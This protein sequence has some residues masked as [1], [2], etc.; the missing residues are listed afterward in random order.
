M[1]NWADLPPDLLNMI[2]SKVFAKDR[3]SLVCRSWYLAATPYRYS[4]PCMMYYYRRNHSWKFHLHD[5]FFFTSF[6]QLNNSQIHCSKYG[7]LLMARNDNTLFFFDPSNNRALDLPC[8]NSFE[9]DKVFF[10][11]PPT[12]PDCIVVTISET[13]RGIEIYLLKRGEYEWE[14]FKFKS[15]NPY[16]VSLALPVLHRGQIILLDM[17]GNL[18]IFNIINRRFVVN[19]EC[20]GYEYGRIYNLIVNEHS[21]FTLKG[22]DALFSVFVFHEER[23]VKVFGLSKVS[24][25]IK[26]KLVEDIGDNVLYVSHTSCF[27][28]TAET[29]ATANRIYFPLF[30]GDSPVFYSLSDKKYHSLNGDYSSNDAYG[31]KRLEFAAWVTPS[32][33]T[34]TSELNTT[35]FRWTSSPR[36]DQHGN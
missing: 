25:K 22:K 16:F 3:F 12:S 31:L 28:C 32:L 1:G 21:L 5:S 19:Y 23:D 27:V 29:K 20:L 10:F 14:H 13:S 7:W 6:P 11:H 35:E 17:R 4:V 2:L 36:V 15:R 30:H 34:T 8:P 9:Y 33:I 26:W 24:K 18:A